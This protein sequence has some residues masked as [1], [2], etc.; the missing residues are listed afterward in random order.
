MV[1]VVVVVVIKVVVIKVVVRVVV[2]FKEKQIG[3][4]KTKFDSV[5]NTS[6]SNFKIKY[7]HSQTPSVDSKRDQDMTMQAT[8]NIGLRESK[9]RERRKM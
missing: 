5:P 6:T 4:V 7:N 8:K 1:V 3:R 9:S 2:R